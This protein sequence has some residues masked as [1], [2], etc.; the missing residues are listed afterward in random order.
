MVAIVGM[1]EVEESWN[2]PPKLPGRTPA[3][4]ASASRDQ[5]ASPVSTFH[6]QVLIRAT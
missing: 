4:S 3:V 6:S 1:H 2:V 5:H